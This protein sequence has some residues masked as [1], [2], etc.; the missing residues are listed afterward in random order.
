MTATFNIAILGSTR[1]SNLPGVVKGLKHSNV[2]IK[3]VISNKINAGILEKAKSD[4][5][6]TMFINSNDQD[7][8]KKLD[9]ALKKNNI[10]L[11]VLIG[12][13][14]ILSPWFVS[15]WKNKI[16]NVH[17]SLL[18][19]HAGLMNLAVHQAV[20]DNHEKQTGCTVH[21]VIDEVDAGSIVVQKR[22]DVLPT[23]TAESLKIRVQQLEVNALIEAVLKNA[24]I[25]NK[26]TK[27][28]E[29]LNL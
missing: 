10:K 24:N 6:S 14:K 3:H 2:K 29:L 23:D 8:E 7:F 16:I 25:Y 26:A 9:A 28:N 15:H 21:W 5:L 19:R 4:G 12:F 11:L 20:L 18:P 22:C 17:P 13:M 27:F 1:G